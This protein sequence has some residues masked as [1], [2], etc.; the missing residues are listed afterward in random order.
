[1]WTNT[2]LILGVGNI[3]KG[4]DG[5]GP[6]F[7]EYFQGKYNGASNTQIEAIDVGTGLTP[8]LLDIYMFPEKPSAI[9]IIDTFVSKKKNGL[10][11]VGEI[12]ELDISSW[13]RKSGFS[14][15]ESHKLPP[16]DI[17]AELKHNGVIVRIFVCKIHDIPEELRM[18]LSDPITKAIP[19][20]YNQ[21]EMIINDIN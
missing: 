18:G 19:R 21:I 3:L 14:F 8:F 12:F 9:I 6:A 11:K 20:I 2:I 13:D 16:S 1:M 17:L 10:Q 7:I 5:F 15:L 4:D